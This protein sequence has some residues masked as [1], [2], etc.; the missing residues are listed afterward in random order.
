M[1][2]FDGRNLA[3]QP[4]LINESTPQG[5]EHQRPLFVRVHPK[6]SELASPCSVTLCFRLSVT[7]KRP[8]R[9]SG[10]ASQ[11]IIHVAFLQ[12][13][14]CAMRSNH[15]SIGRR[16]PKLMTGRVNILTSRLVIF[17]C[18]SVLGL[19]VGCKPT[20]RI[21]IYDNF[22]LAAN[23]HQYFTCLCFDSRA[24]GDERPLYLQIRNRDPLKLDDLTESYFIASIESLD[25]GNWERHQHA[26]HFSGTS[27]VTSY[28][29][30][31][32]VS[33]VLTF[34]NGRIRHGSFHKVDE[35][36]SFSSSPDGP[37]V[38]LGLTRSE[39]KKAFGRPK[40]WDTRTRGG[41]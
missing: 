33:S 35:I 27:T 36:F 13:R 17:T 24:G 23:D 22:E 8:A 19:V 38:E 39:L 3:G 26:P 37:F 7:S 4:P 25:D 11:Q 41:V 18:A 2:S 12:Q 15:S 1:R 34:E 20:A 6:K 28:F 29:A 31:S 5:I 16:I 32:G 30:P 9:S 10:N 40:R 14:Q 21:A